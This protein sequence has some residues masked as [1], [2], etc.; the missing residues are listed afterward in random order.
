MTGDL[1]YYLGGD[2]AT[3]VA[4]WMMDDHKLP[5]LGCA[6]AGVAI[7]G[8]VPERVA[9]AAGPEAALSPDGLDAYRAV[10]RRALRSHRP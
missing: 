9:I 8:S 3:V 4:D 6:E 1:R 5:I 7:W 10:W 2:I